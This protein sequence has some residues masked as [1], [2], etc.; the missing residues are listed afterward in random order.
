MS[1]DFLRKIALV[2][3]FERERNLSRRKEREH[4]RPMQKHIPERG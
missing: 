1:E 3:D 4:F 2:L